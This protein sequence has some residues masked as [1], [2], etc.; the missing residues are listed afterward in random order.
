MTHWD[1]DLN[2]PPKEL[3]K[4]YKKELKEAEYKH[5]LLLALEKVYWYCTD[6][7][8]ELHREENRISNEIYK[9]KGFIKKYKK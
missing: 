2:T 1:G 3:V 4:G 5:G 7:T 8:Q 9:L 6:F